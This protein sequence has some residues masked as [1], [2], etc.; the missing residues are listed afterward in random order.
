MVLLGVIVRPDS[1]AELAWTGIDVMWPEKLP[2]SIWMHVDKQ[3]K[4][5]S[6]QRRMLPQLPNHCQ[7]CCCGWPA[8]LAPGGCFHPSKDPDLEEPQR[9]PQ[10][11]PA[12]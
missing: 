2:C 1:R 6:S 10:A 3:H 12:C 8:V 4:W 9:M 11:G 7:R 5:G